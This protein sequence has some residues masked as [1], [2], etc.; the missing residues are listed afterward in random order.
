M[1][2]ENDIK[3]D[4]K[5]VLIRPKRST[6]KSRSQVSV[7]REFNFK[8]SSKT[9]TG[10]PIMVANMDTTGTF[11]IAIAASAHKIITCIHKHY[12]L[13]EWASFAAANPDA[14]NYVA[15]SA[16]SSE[17]DMVKLQEILILCPSIPF[18]CLD[19]ANGYSEFFIE[20]VRKC[21]GLFPEHIII[22]GNVVTCE[23]TEELI[24]SGADV[25]KVGIGPGSVCTTRKQTG[26]GY[27]QLSAVIECADAAHGLGGHVV[28][29][30]GCTCPGDFSKALGAGGDFVMTGGMFAGHDESGGE[31]VVH[32][33]G[34]KVKL[35]YGMSS[36]TAMEK[37]SGGVANYRSSEGKT[38]SV[39]YKGSVSNTILDILGGIRSSCT[40]VG[41]ST[42]KE[43]PKRTTFIR[44]TQQLNNVWGTYDMR[45]PGLPAK[46]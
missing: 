26:V 10:V 19:V 18:I 37:H 6:L 14:L 35:F 23:M 39:P 29:D 31:L 16:G 30:G 12:T 34:T 28:S 9:W 36:A 22:A 32:E 45:K 40:Y 7:E 38:V 20:C 3:L 24:L 44:V 5:D 8:H 21:R 25:I 46:K 27:P 1:R 43:L 2:I 4:F 15:A 41:A 42:I 33:D 11:E 13:S 17:S